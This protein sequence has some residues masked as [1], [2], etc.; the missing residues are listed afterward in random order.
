[1]SRFKFGIGQTI[2][3]SSRG[4]RTFEAETKRTRVPHFWQAGT[5]FEVLRLFRAS[6]RHDDEYLVRYKGGDEGRMNR[7][8]LDERWDEVTG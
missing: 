4:L 6:D 7:V 8:L 2:R 1:M 5:T 3:L